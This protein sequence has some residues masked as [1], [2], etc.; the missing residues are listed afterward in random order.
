[1]RKNIYLSELPDIDVTNS[2][3]SYLIRQTASDPY[4]M[5]DRTVIMNRNPQNDNPQNDSIG[6]KN[7]KRKIKNVINQKRIKKSIKKIDIYNIL[8]NVLYINGRSF[9]TRYKIRK[10]ILR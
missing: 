7:K 5:E 8:K 2:A 9:S 1:M 4:A 10:T 6:G 3:Y